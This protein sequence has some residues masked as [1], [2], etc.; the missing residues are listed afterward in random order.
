MQDI[1]GTS[2]SFSDHIGLVGIW[3]TDWPVNDTVKY[4]KETVG[5]GTCIPQRYVQSEEKDKANFLYTITAPG[6]N[7]FQYHTT[8]TSMKETFGYKTPEAWFA[9][10]RKWKEELAH[11]VTVKIKGI[12]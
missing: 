6:N 1:V 8:F 5:L 3:G 9:Y 11:P 4:A 2:K 10:L 12:R 7:Y